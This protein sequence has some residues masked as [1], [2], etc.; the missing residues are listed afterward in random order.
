MSATSVS[1]S[2]PRRLRLNAGPTLGEPLSL[3]GPSATSCHCLYQES[4][5]GF[6]L[7]LL[8]IQFQPEQRASRAINLIGSSS[9]YSPQSHALSATRKAPEG[10][11]K[12]SRYK[13]LGSISAV[14][15]YK[16]LSGA[17]T[18]CLGLAWRPSEGRKQAAQTA[19]TA[20]N[21]LIGPDEDDNDNNSN[22]NNNDDRLWAN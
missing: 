11:P 3:P 10:G 14:D 13:W 12:G 20:D 19:T 21:Q 1:T 15:R 7:D 9:S 18:C 16:G 4:L 17:I 8:Q 2:R 5:S 22:S 6:S